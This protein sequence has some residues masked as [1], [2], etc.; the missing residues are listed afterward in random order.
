MVRN[1]PKRLVAP[2]WAGLLV[3]LR[4]LRGWSTTEMAQAAGMD[5][6]Q[7]GRY[8]R[9]E[10]QPTRKNLERL[11]RAARFS[12]PHCERLLG[13]IRELLAEPDT[14]SPGE[15][16]GPVPASRFDVL[17][18][19]PRVRGLLAAPR[20][21]FSQISSD[22]AVRAEILLT[23]LR[24]LPQ[25]AWT[26]VVTEG[27]EYHTPAFCSR[28]CTASR[29]A[30]ADSPETAV[31]LA[32]LAVEAA[33]RASAAAFSA[34][35]YAFLGNA[36]R[37]AGDLRPGADRA[38][39]RSR[40]LRRPGS[41]GELEPA[42]EALL[43]DLEASLRRD[44]RRFDAALA[45][46]EQALALGSVQATG[47]LLLNKAATFQLAERFESALAVL[48]ET[49]PHVASSPFLHFAQLFN[50]AANLCELG[51]F[52]EA[53]PRLP[54]IRALA[55]ELDRPILRV[56]LLWLEAKV[57]AG[58]GRREEALELLGGVV[59][60]FAA[61]RVPYDAAL[62]ALELAVW[63]L[64]AGETDAVRRLAAQ[65][66]PI[67][68]QQKIEREWCGTVKLFLEAARRDTLTAERARDWLRRLR[69]A[70]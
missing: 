17:L 59:R 1:R 49:E 58:T 38:F 18:R 53:E 33:G 51:R 3:L 24:T 55:E 8:E 65:I 47:L 28:L 66:A 22:D 57:A 70:G 48:A 31:A 64:E 13:L 21:E 35:A 56:R 16:L 5:R 62:A 46:H 25:V 15:P 34:R 40:E 4:R 44:Q 6:S 52:A 12:W 45:L 63:H 2:E 23:R 27:L 20:A 68:Q 10:S 19:F 42:E 37:V 61:R 11:A 32:Q 7:L 29:E 30:V 9:R 26:R 54:A 43:I 69:S 39:A 14:N 67:F 41:P 50:Q 36:L 60:E